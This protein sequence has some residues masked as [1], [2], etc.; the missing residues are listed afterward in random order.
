MPDDGFRYE[1]VEGELIRMA[2][3]GAEHG[4]V[5]VKITGPLFTHVA[6]NDLGT[7]YAAETGF[8]LHSDPDT[9]RAPD[10]AF[11]SKARVE[12]VG[13]TRGY[14]VGAPDLA[15]EVVSPGDTVREVEEK[16]R[17]WLEAGAR[18]VLVVS[19]RLRTITVYRSLTDINVFT[20]K[21]TLD[22]DDVVPGFRLAVVEV[23]R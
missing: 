21:D 12:L 7:V 6:A 19:P 18:M 23:F 4:K 17:E 13:T 15:I 16:V 22:G 9:V 5:T 2:P 11:V 20:E 8:K 3:A 10:V 14:W 1:L